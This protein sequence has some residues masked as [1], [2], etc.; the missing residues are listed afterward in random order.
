MLKMQMDEEGYGRVA[1]L[2][3]LAVTESEGSK[4][5]RKEIVYRRYILVGRIQY[6]LMRLSD[7]F[8]LLGWFCTFSHGRRI[9]LSGIE[10]KP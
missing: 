2:L 6:S 9:T 5:H 8:F 7:F 1:K 10:L 3:E 4:L